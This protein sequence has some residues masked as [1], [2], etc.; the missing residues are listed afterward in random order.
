MV[1]SPN[2]AAPIFRVAQVKS[3]QAADRGTRRK[4]NS[5]DL[6]TLA[7]PLCACSSKL[8]RRSARPFT[9]VLRILSK[10][11]GLGL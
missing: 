7:S 1:R 11:E 9:A 10:L 3:A 5:A 6:A 4:R 8:T 2:S